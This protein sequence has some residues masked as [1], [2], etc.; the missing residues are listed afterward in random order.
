MG[1]FKNKISTIVS[2]I[3]AAVLSFLGFN[4]TSEVYVM[5]GMP[6]GDFEI[7]GSVTDSATNLP[8]RNAQI[9]AKYPN[10]ANQTVINIARTDSNGNYTLTGNAVSDRLQ[11][12]CTPTDITELRPDTLLVT[13]R[14][15]RSD[16]IANSPR[17]YRGAAKT[18][19]DFVLKHK[20]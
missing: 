19:A 1:N 7:K 2:V 17:F 18:N 3:S 10:E 8:V 6:T 9:K 11:I 16:S 15:H 14:Y 12:I 5:Y 13:L 4:A 20:K